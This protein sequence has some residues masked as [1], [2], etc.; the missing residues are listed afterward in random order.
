MPTL[1]RSRP[2]RRGLALFA[3]TSLLALGAATAQLAWSQSGDVNSLQACETRQDRATCE[4]ELR[5]ARAEQ[6]RGTLEVPGA[7]LQANALA[8]CAPFTG[9][10]RTA[11]EARAMGQGR[12][13][14]SVAGG[15]LL[16]EAETVVTPPPAAGAAPA[17]PAP[18][19][20]PSPPMPAVQGR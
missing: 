10:D 3:T 8:R 13:S 12:T 18:A 16:R 9:E 11:C 4:R 19:A 15:G 2:R 17:T 6:R 20:E 7:D 1:P 5:N 14:G